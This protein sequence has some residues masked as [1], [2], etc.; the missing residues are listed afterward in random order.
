MN[1]NTAL[2][3]D[4]HS[5]RQGTEVGTYSSCLLTFVLNDPPPHIP[6]KQQDNE[7]VHDNSVENDGAERQAHLLLDLEQP[8]QHFLVGKTVEVSYLKGQDGNG[9]LG[10]GVGV[11]GQPSQHLLQAASPAEHDVISEAKAQVLGMVQ[12]SIR[13]AWGNE[14]DLQLRNAEASESNALLRI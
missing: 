5:G 3:A 10:H 11:L 14:L 7:G 12:A 13:H 9:E 6:Y 8:A 4:V 1:I 2:Y